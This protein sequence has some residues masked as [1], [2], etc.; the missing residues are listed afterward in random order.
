[1]PLSLKNYLVSS[2]NLPSGTPFPWEEWDKALTDTIAKHKS[3]TAKSLDKWYVKIIRQSTESPI[4]NFYIVNK[5]TYATQKDDVTIGHVVSLFSKLVETSSSSPPKIANFTLNRSINSFNELNPNNPSKK[6]DSAG[7]LK[8]YKYGRS[9]FR[10]KKSSL[11]KVFAA[12]PTSDTLFDT[13][14]KPSTKPP[15]VRKS[16]SNLA[17]DPVS[18][19]TYS[20][21]SQM[22]DSSTN[23]SQ[24][25]PSSSDPDDFNHFRARYPSPPLPKAHKKLSLD[26]TLQH[27]YEET[28]RSSAPTHPALHLSQSFGKLRADLTNEDT[29]PLGQSDFH[30]PQGSGKPRTDSASTT[31]DYPFVLGDINALLE[32]NKS[33]ANSTQ[34][35]ASSVMASPISSHSDHHSGMTSPSSSSDFPARHFENYILMK[36]SNYM[37][38]SAYESNSLNNKDCVR[39]PFVQYEKHELPKAPPPLSPT[40]SSEQKEVFTNEDFESFY[41]E[42]LSKHR[43]PPKIRPSEIY[44]VIPDKIYSR[45][46]SPEYRPLHAS[47]SSATIN[48]DY[49][50]VEHFA[51]VSPS[52]SASQSQ[53]TGDIRFYN[54]HFHLT[55]S[56]K[57]DCAQLYLHLIYAINSLTISPNSLVFAVPSSVLNLSLHTLCITNIAP[58]NPDT[59]TLT[60][61]QNSQLLYACAVINASFRSKLSATLTEPL[62]VLQLV[63]L[64]KDEAA[65]YLHQNILSHKPLVE[66]CILELNRLQDTH[67]SEAKPL[68]SKDVIC[69]FNL[70]Q[71]TDPARSSAQ[72]PL[73]VV[74]QSATCLSDDYPASM[75]INLAELHLVDDD[76]RSRYCKPVREW[77][78]V[79]TPLPL[80]VQRL[81]FVN[82]HTAIIKQPLSTPISLSIG[83]DAFELYM[84]LIHGMQQGHYAPTDIVLTSLQKEITSASPALSN[85]ATDI[86]ATHFQISGILPANQYSG[87]PARIEEA[88]NT[89]KIINRLKEN[90]IVP[91][92]TPVQL[93]QFLLFYRTFAANYLQAFQQKS[94]SL[95]RILINNLTPHIQK[96]QQKSSEPATAR[97]LYCEITP[98]S[99]S[100]IYFFDANHSTFFATPHIPLDILHSEF[101]SPPENHWH[102]GLFTYND[103]GYLTVSSPCSILE[104]HD[105]LKLQTTVYH[106]RSNLTPFCVASSTEILD[107]LENLISQEHFENFV[108]AFPDTLQKSS[109]SPNLPAS[110]LC[111]SRTIENFNAIEGGFILERQ[112]ISELF[113]TLL[114][115]AEESPF[116][117]TML[118]KLLDQHIRP[119]S[120]GNDL[121]TSAVTIKEFRAFMKAIKDLAITNL[122]YSLYM[123]PKILPLVEELINTQF[124]AS[125]HKDQPCSEFSVIIPIQSLCSNDVH[126][127]YNNHSFTLQN[128][129]IIHEEDTVGKNKSQYQLFA[130][131]DFNGIQQLI[132]RYPACTIADC[133]RFIHYITLKS[134]KLPNDT[135]NYATLMLQEIENLPSG[136]SHF[137]SYIKT[138]ILA[139]S[140]T[141]NTRLLDSLHQQ[142]E[143]LANSNQQFRAIQL[144]EILIQ[145][146]TDKLE[147]SSVR[148]YH[149]KI[150]LPSESFKTLLSTPLKDLPSS[151]SNPKQAALMLLLKY[152][153]ATIAD[154]GIHLNQYLQIKSAT[155]ATGLTDESITLEQLEEQLHHPQNLAEFKSSLKLQTIQTAFENN[156]SL[157]NQLLGALLELTDNSFSNRRKPIGDFTI[158]LIPTDT[159]LTSFDVQLHHRQQ[160]T[161]VKALASSIS[162]QLDALPILPMILS[163]ISSS[164]DDA[165]FTLDNL[166]HILQ[167]YISQQ[168]RRLL[169][170]QN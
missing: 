159:T 1:M 170:A 150:P 117:K 9:S 31:S 75:Y 107:I 128:M 106:S 134:A 15:K 119:K 165:S 57:Y 14:K 40:A 158:A 164:G 10:E 39:V 30:F 50:D 36:G 130:L 12:S 23:E 145:L 141:Q 21:T 110:N 162:I 156:P 123:H 112:Q 168:E 20:H 151:S 79:S 97:K 122:A 85:N 166:K 120:I 18:I 102:L 153:G 43:K 109:C 66:Q 19:P 37:N 32:I 35:N 41:D 5:Y 44:E 115:S 104:L 140:C 135:A 137:R 161:A 7:S 152:E 147:A 133:S 29:P 124:L 76:D 163:S 138:N 28:F 101:A 87:K 154:Y 67:P 108:V 27:N 17:S 132:K 68:S 51:P 58:P 155:S 48:H 34:S 146:S 98:P 91:I 47:Q 93:G 113:T 111:F 100:S 80:Y 49:E 26:T 129:E 92:N 74:F 136:I 149:S 118:P 143:A 2:F 72:L 103:L 83:V 13:S 99:P 63:S 125:M 8:R 24:Q 59:S 144:S 139:E 86:N 88:L 61:S 89:P 11:P 105:I 81:T 121:T 160:T 84:G 54:K 73:N 22:S 4:Y 71:P 6:E 77:P 78:L 53:D 114:N 148:I 69:T 25:L 131:S 62:T 95:A 46:T 142:I 157:L 82:Q 38:V 90:F 94:S 126:Y 60:E 42:S 70:F 3:L 55:Q 65:E 169:E 116:N 16:T 127:P 33:R 167:H 64:L 56:N 45:S 96:N 52:L